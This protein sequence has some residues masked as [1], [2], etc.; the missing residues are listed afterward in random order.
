MCTATHMAGWPSGRFLPRIRSLYHVHSNAHGR[1]AIRP[2]PATNMVILYHIRHIFQSTVLGERELQT[3]FRYCS[4]VSTTRRFRASPARTIPGNHQVA[5]TAGAKMSALCSIPDHRILH[6]NSMVCVHHVAVSG[7]AVN[8]NRIPSSQGYNRNL[9]RICHRHHCG[10]T[11]PSSSAV[12][13]IS[14]R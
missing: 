9:P 7:E 14:V 3:G 2:F 5:L 11:A 13:I 8:S 1:M 6:L 4:L 10:S 12:T